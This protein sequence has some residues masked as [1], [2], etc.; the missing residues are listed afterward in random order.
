MGESVSI[1]SKSVS[2]QLFRLYR[3]LRTT[4]E[5]YDLGGLRNTN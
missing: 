3:S 4:Q 2:R 1:E 5:L